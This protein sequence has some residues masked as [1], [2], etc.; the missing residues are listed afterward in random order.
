MEHVGYNST[1]E[2][3]IPLGLRYLGACILAGSNGGD[4]RR[5]VDQADEAADLY[6]QAWENRLRRLEKQRVSSAVG[7]AG[8]Q[9]NW[10][11]GLQFITGESRR[12]SRRGEIR[13]V[14]QVGRIQR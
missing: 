12:R 9:K 2:S 5:A 4:V 14:L 1:K 3:E 8:I 10:S 13:P 11:S 7:R 6:E